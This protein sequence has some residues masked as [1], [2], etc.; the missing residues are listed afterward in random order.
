MS[1][2]A[3]SLDYQYS[4]PLDLRLSHG[5]ACLGQSDPTARVK[6]GL[7]ERAA[8]T[9]EGPVAYEL[10]NASGTLRVRAWGPGRQWALDHAPALAG[11]ED[12]PLEFRPA[13]PA[14]RRLK[15]ACAG[16]RLSRFPSLYALAI[17][18]VIRQKV[19]FRDAHRNFAS[20]VRQLGQPAP[21]PL[22]LRLVPTPTALRDAAEHVYRAA[23]IDGQ[24][25][26]VLRR[27][28]QVAERLEACT[29]LEQI[30]ALLSPIA[31]FGPWTRAWL[32]GMGLGDSDVVPIGDYHLAHT[33]C[34]ALA[35]EPRGDD[36]AMLR[37]LDAYRGQRFRVVRL[38]FA[39]GWHAPRF[40]PRRATRIVSLKSHV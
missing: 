25:E 33:V 1:D 14:L 5:L 16:L 2:A 38:L 30:D 31:G 21:G 35:G 18:Y 40:G 29:T 20:L 39:A 26:R 32:A 12:D 36:A 4:G 37:H 13:H 27:L 6:P 9:P 19:T 7:S 15:S 3:L 24:R 11:I 22:G 28:A 10:S 17:A 8:F 23:G 34:W